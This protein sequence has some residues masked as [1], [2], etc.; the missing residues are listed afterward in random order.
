METLKNGKIDP[1][2]EHLIIEHNQ[3]DIESGDPT[4]RNNG[5]EANWLNQRY[6][7]GGWAEDEGKGRVILLRKPLKDHTVTLGLQE[8]KSGNLW[9][10]IKLSGRSV[11]DW[12]GE[13]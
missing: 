8:I 1:M 3:Q 11:L 7:I 12:F 2:V 9:Q 5:I 13:D 10:H 4:R 6:G